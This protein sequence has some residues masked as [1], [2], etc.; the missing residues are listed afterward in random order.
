MTRKTLYLLAFVWFSCSPAIA[1]NSKARAEA[2]KLFGLKYYEQ[3]L[4]HF[5]EAIKA[6]EKD[7]MVHYKAGVSYSK[8]AEISD[9]VKAIPFLEYALKNGKGLPN[10][11]YYDLGSLYLKDE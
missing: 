5:E 7:P 8:A 2:E 10:T 3:A 4:P 1:Q 9:Q 6:G 11:V